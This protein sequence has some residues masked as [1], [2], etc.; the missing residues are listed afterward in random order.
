MLADTGAP[1]AT[2]KVDGGVSLWD[3]LLQYQADFGGAT[4]E[5]PADVETTAKGAA[6]AAGIGAGV[7]SGPADV[8]PSHRRHRRLH[9][10]D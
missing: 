1:L 6:I 4:V 3:P 10:K 9:A 8:S 5:R 7:W 2:I